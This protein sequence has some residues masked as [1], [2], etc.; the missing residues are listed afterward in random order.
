[1]QTRVGLVAAGI[2][3][4]DPIKSDRFRNRGNSQRG[5][6]TPCRSGQVFPPREFECGSPRGLTRT[7]ACS[8]LIALHLVTRIPLR[9]AHCLVLGIICGAFQAASGAEPGEAASP[10]QPSRYYSRTWQTDDGLPRNSISAIAQTPDGYLWLGTPFG[11]IRYDGTTFTPMEDQLVGGNPS[12]RTR[13]LFLDQQGRL[14]MG[15]ATAGILRWAGEEAK[16]IGEQEIMS[17]AAVT[18]ICEDTSGTIWVTGGS[19]RLFRV[20]ENDVVRSLDPLPGPKNLDARLARDGSG[21]VW[22]TQGT[23]YGRIVNG[24]ATNVTRVPGGWAANLCRSRDGGVWIGIGDE[25]HKVHPPETGLKDQLLSLPFRRN[26]V[27]CMLED[28]QGQLWLGT[29]GQGLFRYAESVFTRE[30]DTPHRITALY[31]DQES[32]LWVGTEGGGLSRLRPRIFRTLS[33][34]QGLPGSLLLS[35]CEDRDGAVWLAPRDWGLSRWTAT[36][37]LEVLGSAADNLSIRTVYPHPEGGVW[38]GTVSRGLLRIQD[39][40]KS[41]PFGEA[42]LSTRQIRALHQD[43]R[44]RLWIGCLPDGLAMLDG[45]QFTG[46]EHFFDQGLGR[47]AIWAIADTPNGDLWLGTIRGELCRYDGNNFLCLDETHGLPGASISALHATTNGDLWIGTLGGGLGLCRDGKISF[48]NMRH[49]LWDDV[50]AAIVDDGAGSFWLGSEQG[51]FRVNQAELEDFFAGRRSRVTSVHYGQD[52]GLRN[53]ELV[54]GYQPAAWKTRAGEIWFA[55]SKGAVA[56]NPALLKQNRYAPPLVLENVLVDGNAT[57]RFG[58]ELRYGYGELEFQY[59]ATSFVASEQIRFRRQLVGLDSDWVEAGKSRSAVYPRLGPGRYVFRFTACSADGVWNEEPVSVA[60]VVTPAFWQ[61]AWFRIIAL[62]A[63]AGLVAVLV[64]YRYVQKM[65]RKLRKLE[66]ARAVE[67]E[68]MRIA[69]DIHDDLGA[70][71]TQMAF[72][73]EMAVGEI[74]GDHQASERLDKIAQGSRQAIRSLD[75]IVWAVNPRKDSLPHLVDYLSHYTNEFFRG[76][77]IRCRLDLPF[78]VPDTSITAEIRHHLFLACK[79]ALNNIRKHAHASE[80]W[81]RVNVNGPELVVTIEDNGQGLPAL[82]NPSAG[83]GLLN[84][85]TRLATLGGQCQ[86]ESRPERGTMVRLSIQLPLSTPA[87]PDSNPTSQA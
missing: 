30:F 83:N 82:T 60:F 87:T 42:G 48:L 6:Q 75:E 40:E 74:G 68:R 81:L 38:L 15:A 64:R 11:I 28:R 71:L 37:G 67:Q 44:G 23:L 1:M 39:G 65:R 16:V 49:G 76:T 21:G 51:I 19:G 63:F 4:D 59:T 24:V 20:D 77:N 85:R 57:N 53:V 33:F 56:V 7:S 46:P 79:E 18:D 35:V 61:T 78:M 54:G 31:E 29:Y 25:L 45:Q 8:I 27:Q 58:L 43:A 10:T 3:A 52:D 9:L 86:I 2:L 80:V 5:D 73:S 26:Q 12:L 41:G 62:L 34:V 69:R 66:Q 17:I 50:I 22:F 55:T 47:N 70:R 32:N 72:L 36:N 13:A 14:W 84:L